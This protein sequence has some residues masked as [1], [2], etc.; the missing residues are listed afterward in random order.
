[1][2]RGFLVHVHSLVVM[3][4]CM[5]SSIVHG[6][7]YT[8]ETDLNVTANGRNGSLVSALFV[9][10]DSSVDCGDNT[11]FYPLLHGRLSLYP[12][13]GSDGTLLPQI[14]ADKIGLTSILP[15]YAQ[16]GSLNEIL[17]GLNFGSTQAMI[18]NQGGF[19]HQS[20][21]QQLRQVSESMQ[22]LQLHLSEN[23]A[24]EFTK[25]SIFFLSFGKEDYIDLFLHNSSNP[26]LNHSAEYFATILVNQMTNA[27]RYLYEAN[28]RKIICLGVLPLGCAPRM[29]WESNQTSDG[30]IDGNGCVDN[31]NN[32]VLEYNRLLNEHI[33][34][35]NAEFSDAHI[36]FCDVYTGILEIIR[37]PRF[38]GFEDTKSACCGLGSNGAMIG[39]ISTELACNQ[40]S[41]HVWWDLL[42][43]TEAVNSILAEAAW[44]NQPIPDLCRPFTIHELVNTKT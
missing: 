28:A 21:N 39:C 23:T 9:L 29:A 17:G 22:L 34:Q 12:C 14:I 13:N 31:V 2:R 7:Q 42:N 4:I 44:S 5:F 38:Y 3:L 11:L 8:E 30:Y 25:S 26:M 1:M 41:A 6:Q 33:V 37:K 18:M 20:L 36:V 32:W 35:L 10:G 40:A 27:M 15:F 19:S 16:N 43:P 24:V